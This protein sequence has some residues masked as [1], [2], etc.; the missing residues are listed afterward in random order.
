M[1]HSLVCEGRPIFEFIR[2]LFFAFFRSLHVFA[3]FSMC[4]SH[5]LTRS[6]YFLFLILPTSEYLLT[7]VCNDYQCSPI[8]ATIAKIQ[9]NFLHKYSFYHCCLDIHFRQMYSLSLF[10]IAPL[11]SRKKDFFKCKFVQKQTLDNISSSQRFV[12]AFQ[13]K[14]VF[15]RHE[16]DFFS[17]NVLKISLLF[18]F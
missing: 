11:S 9:T 15:I 7:I 2:V 8:K 12:T 3:F 13:K 5:L 17:K 14:K 6:Y 10:L 18:L 1:L 16:K 4:M